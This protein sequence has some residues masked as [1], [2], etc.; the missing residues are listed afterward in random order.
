[1]GELNIFPKKLPI[2]LI[3]FP[4]V[5]K[6]TFFSSFSVSISQ[7]LAVEFNDASELEQMTSPGT[8]FIY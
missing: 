2:E 1:M 7:S 5:K 3:N 6:H 8:S 4:L